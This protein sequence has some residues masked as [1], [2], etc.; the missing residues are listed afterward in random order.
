[1]GAAIGLALAGR[2]P[3]AEIQ[4]LG[5]SLQG[6]HQVLGQLARIRYRS[7]GGLHCP[8]TLRAPYG[9]GVRAP[10]LHSDTLD[11]LLAQ[12]P[13]LKVVAPSS[14]EDARGLLA[15]AIRDPDPVVVLEPLALYR[16]SQRPRPDADHLVPIGKA[17]TVRPGK[18]CTLIT[19]GSLVPVCVEAAERVEADTSA[20][21]RVVDLRSLAP[22]DI[23]AVVDAAETGRVVVAHESPLTGGFGAEVVATIQQEAFFSLAAPVKR[24]AGYDVPFPP[25]MLEPVQVPSA[26]RVAAAVHDV[27]G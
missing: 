19:W 27:L 2:V 9:G 3:V 15:S 11:G 17:R 7:R 26:A 4:F 8:V 5:F 6:L 1:V 12:T 23:D 25:A 21:V 22:L 10:E 18:S 14:P 20:T 13:G 24:V 16:H